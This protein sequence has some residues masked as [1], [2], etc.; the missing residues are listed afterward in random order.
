MFHAFRKA[1][2]I[3]FMN[4]LLMIRFSFS[5]ECVTATA[6]V[7]RPTVRTSTVCVASFS[8]K[9]SSKT[10]PTLAAW[11]EILSFNLLLLSSEI[12]IFSTYKSDLLFINCS[13]SFTH[14]HIISLQTDWVWCSVEVYST[15][16]YRI[17]QNL[18]RF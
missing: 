15:F 7:N 13:S 16:E 1:D 3:K 2:Y 17:S 6:T 9:D 18:H 10:T 8:R 11:R 5:V 12:S 14:D 4:K